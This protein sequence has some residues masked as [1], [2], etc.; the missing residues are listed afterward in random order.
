MHTCVSSHTYEHA[1]TP[2]IHIRRKK[3]TTTTTVIVMTNRRTSWVWW[4][5]SMV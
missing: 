2:Y 5:M 4:Y 1:Y 3:E